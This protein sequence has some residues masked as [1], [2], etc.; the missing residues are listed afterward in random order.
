VAAF[1]NELSRGSVGFGTPDHLRMGDPVRLGFRV[2]DGPAFVLL[3]EVVS[4]SVSDGTARYQ[5]RFKGFDAA[6][7][8]ELREF[9]DGA[10]GGASG[11]SV[12]RAQR[13]EEV[14][15]QSRRFM[16]EIVL[17]VVV[18]LVIALIAVLLLALRRS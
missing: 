5:A 7:Q 16:R 13:I 14:S 1:L 12:E 9:V 2:S 17:G 11:S 10:T 15:V 3:A 4:S 6:A 8:K 18:G